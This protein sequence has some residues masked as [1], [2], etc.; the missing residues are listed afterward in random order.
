MNL[1]RINSGSLW[2]TETSLNYTDMK[3]GIISDLLN[4]IGKV[5]QGSL[6]VE[7]IAAVYVN[8]TERYIAIY[9]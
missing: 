9:Y 2:N 4:R 3:N 5:K 6:S 1:T 8:V 7:N